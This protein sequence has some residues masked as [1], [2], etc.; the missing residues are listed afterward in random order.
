MYILFLRQFFNVG[1]MSWIQM[2]VDKWHF[3]VQ[4]VLKY[5]GKQATQ[6]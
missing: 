4:V 2:F 3:F 5:V 6:S 1:P